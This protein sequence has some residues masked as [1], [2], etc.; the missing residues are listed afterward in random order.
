[1]TSAHN[2]KSTERLPL[3]VKVAYGAAEGSS[4]L[5][6]IV[7]GIYFLIFLTDSVG[8]SPSTGGA[9]LFAAVMGNAMTDPLMGIISDRTRSRYGRR[10]PYIIAAA[11]PFC[12]IFWLLFSTPRLEGSALALYYVVMALLMYTAITVLDVPYTA[13]APEMTRDYDERTNLVGFRVA[14]SQL[15]SII[16]GA[17]P[18]MI[19]Q[20]FADQE[21]G[22]SAMA[23]IL[24]AACF[25]PILLTWRFTR[26]Y[27]LYAEDVEPLSFKD[28]KS[29]LLGNRS[30]RYVVGVYFFGI[31][32]VY[33]VSAIA[34]YF[35][36]YYIGFDETQ[37]SIFFLFLFTC[38]LL[39]V[40][41]ITFTSNRIGKR[42][43]Y[44]LFI[45]AWAL[46]FG[47]GNLLVQPG[48]V[49]LMYCVALLAAAGMCSTYQL[50]WAMIPDVVEVDELKTGK[51]REGLYY[52]V[53]IFVLKAGSA[54]AL[55]LVGQALEWIGYIPGAVQSPTVLL[56]LRVMFGPLV[57]GLLL[58]SVVL[59][60]FMPMT[61]DRH[62]ALLEAIRAKKAGEKWDE[63]GFR[64]LL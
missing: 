24:G 54:F 17:A 43:A 38:M 50:C 30:F 11:V 25:F 61:R 22:W 16:G 36:E 34:V 15:G 55:L 51:R 56:G 3:G 59:A 23:A 29:A 14:W 27:E 26:G 4:S 2:D 33:L 41:V 6:F 10:R 19:V 31:T 52:G 64:K 20:M 9:I 8:L 21:T 47:I 39:C 45:S 32:S 57:A 1:M 44:M 7:V 46:L 13:L 28:I 12:V 42:G 62:K 63:E 18:L 37:T 35:M 58:I 49:V 60:Y 40:P 48:Q 53:A 5:V